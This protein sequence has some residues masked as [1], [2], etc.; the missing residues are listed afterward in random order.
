MPSTS[1]TTIDIL[2]H[3]RTQ[4]DD[5]LRGRIDVKLSE[6]GFKQMQQ[7]VAPY[8]NQH[9]N[10][11]ASA[12]WQQLIS[13]PLQRCAQFADHLQQQHGTPVSIDHGFLE[14]DFGDWDGRDLN[15]LQAENPKL[16]TNIWKK[17]EQYSPPNG[18]NIQDFSARITEAWQALIDQYSGQHILLI[19][20]GGVIRALLGGILQAPLSSLSRFQVPYASMSRVKIHHH[21]DEQPWP[22]LVFHNPH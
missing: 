12:P 16:F 20:H 9:D 5:I 7:R 4:A 10:S 1:V 19:C 22:Q 13:S 3:G 21:D 8:I 2:R 15:E 6:I 18:E 14:M 17:P 11:E